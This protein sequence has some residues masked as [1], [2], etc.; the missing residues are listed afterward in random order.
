[1]DC[2]GQLI[3]IYYDYL[4]P[5]DMEKMIFK[6]GIEGFPIC[7][8]QTHNW[9]E[10]IEVGFPSVAQGLFPLRHLLCL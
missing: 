5:F 4:W 1:M 6:T 7:V 3:S 9:P 2:L 8:R 10:Q